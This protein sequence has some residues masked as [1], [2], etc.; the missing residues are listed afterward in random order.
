MTTFAV[1]DTSSRG[2]PSSLA[3]TTCGGDTSLIPPYALP[4][5][6]R[7]R[8]DRSGFVVGT[9]Q[10]AR[11]YRPSATVPS[12]SRPATESGR[13]T[14]KLSQ[15]AAILSPERFSGLP[16][17]DKRAFPSLTVPAPNRP[18]R[19]NSLQNPDLADRDSRPR[20][21]AE[22]NPNRPLDAGDVSIY[23]ANRGL[24][25]GPWSAVEGRSSGGV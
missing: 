25:P 15:H 16:I 4:S 2:C 18:E 6:I 1:H 20:P 23:S 5:T 3:G 17:G 12:Y 11:P 24:R 9:A 14:P 22:F 21:V 19:D 7:C 8:T 13:R 10:A